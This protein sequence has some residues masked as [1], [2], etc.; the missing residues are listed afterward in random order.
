MARRRSE[1]PRH[2]VLHAILLVWTVISLYPLLWVLAI[3][4]SGQQSLMFADPP[5]VASAHS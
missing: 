3:A 4:F 1:E 2:Y 5:K